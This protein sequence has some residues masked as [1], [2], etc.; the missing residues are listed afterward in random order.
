MEYYFG[1]VGYPWVAP[2]SGTIADVTIK[3][4]EA[5]AGRSVIVAFYSASETTALPETKIASAE[6]SVNATGE[7]TQT[8]F[9]GTPTVERGTLYWVFQASDDISGGGGGQVGS[10]DDT[11][12]VNCPTNLPGCGMLAA[13]YFGDGQ[14]PNAVNLIGETDLP[15][16]VDESTCQGIRRDLIDVIVGW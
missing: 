9:T 4:T 2:H 13:T 11:A 14:F 8:S 12:T 15:A 5:S 7:I 1:P 10:R 3:C 6:C 16:T